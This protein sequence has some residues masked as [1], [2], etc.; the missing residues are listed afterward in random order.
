M[1][2]PENPA[3]KIRLE[4][5][6]FEEDPESATWPGVE[7]S[8]TEADEARAAERERESTEARKYYD[9]VKAYWQRQ[10]QAY[11]AFRRNNR[12]PSPD[13]DGDDPSIGPHSYEDEFGCTPGTLDL[14]DDDSEVEE[15]FGHEYSRRLRCMREGSQMQPSTLQSEPLNGAVARAADEGRRAKLT[16][17][18]PLKPTHSNALETMNDYQSPQTTPSANKLKPSD[19]AAVGPPE[20][21]ELA[22]LWK[23]PHHA[24]GTSYRTDQGRQEPRISPPA[25]RPTLAATARAREEG[26]KARLY[27]FPPLEPSHFGDSQAVKNHDRSPSH[28]LQGHQSPS[29]RARASRLRG[30]DHRR[31][32]RTIRAAIA[33]TSRHNRAMPLTRQ[34]VHQH[35][36]HSFFFLKLDA[37]GIA[38]RVV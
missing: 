14:Q 18:L 7:D 26:R 37:H 32:Q 17:F 15:V 12:L 11:A 36:G 13:L 33:A 29:A 2:Y 28:S 3:K 6:V 38:R 30:T 20:M 25:V 34:C 31:T 4:A 22:W 10:R 27:K 35:P 9:R 16:K 5:E 24:L 1:F 8:I 21:Q 23:T 19:A